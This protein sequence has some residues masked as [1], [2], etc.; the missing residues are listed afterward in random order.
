[1]KSFQLYAVFFVWQYATR[2]SIVR[3]IHEFRTDAKFSHYSQLQVAEY[4]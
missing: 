2:T 1:M 4:V 3:H